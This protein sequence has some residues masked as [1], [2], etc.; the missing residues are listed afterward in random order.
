MSDIPNDWPLWMQF[1]EMS[2][3]L[4]WRVMAVL[5]VSAAVPAG[6]IL[7]LRLLRFIKPVA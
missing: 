1:T 3:R 6:L 5:A 4:L 7:G 2:W